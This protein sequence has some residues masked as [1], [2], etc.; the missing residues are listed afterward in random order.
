VSS[1][2]T[3][4]VLI[5]TGTLHEEGDDSNLY[6]TIFG[7]NGQTKKMPLNETTKTNKKNEK[8]EY[9]FKT[10]DIGKVC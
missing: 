10:K 9:E 1:E 4:K 7:Q 5:R 6:L 8:I 3:Y 2:T